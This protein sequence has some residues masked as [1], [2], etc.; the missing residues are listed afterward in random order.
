MFAGL[1]LFPVGLWNALL[2][3]IGSVG[4]SRQEKDQILGERIVRFC[5]TM[6][7][8]Y[9]KFGQIM[10]T[11]SD[12]FSADTIRELQRLQDDVPPSRKRDVDAVLKE[13]YGLER[14]NVFAWFGEEPIASAS[15]AQVHEARLK[16]GE[17]VAVKIVKRRVPAAL[18]ANLRFLAGAVKIMHALVPPIRHFNGPA[19]IRELAALLAPQIDM[20]REGR[21]M[22]HVARNFS[23]HPFVIIPDVHEA[24]C[25]ERV[26]VM[27]YVEG[28]PGR[29][30]DQVALP[31][32]QLARRLQD[33]VYTMLYM[34]GVAHGDPHPGN[35]RFTKDGKIIFLDFGITVHVSE[36]EKWGLASFLFASIRQEWDLATER[37]LV[38]FVIQ[39]GQARDRRTLFED[40]KAVIVHYFHEIADE[41][42]TAD[43]F[44]DITAVLKRHEAEYT[45]NFTKVELALASCEGFGTQIDPDIDVWANSRRFSDKYSPYMND[46]VREQF[47]EFFQSHTPRTMAM[48]DD[49]EQ[50][51]IASI[52][53]NRYFFPCTYPMFAKKAYGCRIEDMDGNVYIDLTGGY[54]PHILGYAHPEIVV[55]QTQLV[56][57]GCLN[58]MGN[59][60]EVELARM[61][62]DA[63]PG[64][65]YAC[66]SNSGTEAVIHALRICRAYRNRGK[67][68]KCEGHYHGFSDQAMVSSWFQQ[69]G[70]VE[71]PDAVAGCPGTPRETVNNTIVLQ[72]GHEESFRILRER[73]EEI[74]CVIME[75][76]PFSMGSMNV[77]FLNEMRSL[78]TELDIPL[79]FDEVVSGFRVAYGGAQ[80]TAGVTPDLTILGKI[81]GGGMP[82]GAVVGTRKLMQIAR[83]T[84][85]PFR[86]YE[87]RVFLG[88][89]MSGNSL[90]AGSGLAML[91]YLKAHPEVYTKLDE[92]TTWMKSALMAV[93]DRLDVPLRVKAIRSIFTVSFS[94][95]D[96]QFYREI[97]GGSDYKASIALAYYMR[98]HGVYMPEL[99]F[100]AL[101]YAHTREDLEIVLKAF[102]ISL[103]EM[104]DDGFFVS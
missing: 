50:F 18:R 5:Q 51:M 61:L 25:A 42:R 69:R 101:S 74:D 63:F 14:E 55:A 3:W 88:G 40:V 1:A 85:D 67:V 68:A 87:T 60:G 91:R 19:R 15:I 49:A 24:Y 41:W 30:F 29:D 8:L 13:A 22:R 65:D 98:K 82:C 80:T 92:H 64:M 48:R 84:A 58:A 52:H 2:Y 27:D 79:V 39:N 7:P 99:H 89:T 26:L 100:L 97:M 102:E 103:Q 56:A 75:P 16:T 12:A 21:N 28:I 46:G 31:R 76:L 47:N 90:S 77:E 70:P 54:G 36:A 94:H 81:I 78:C 35:V 44:A 53:M 104:K 83:S 95:R 10:S 23:N 66:L 59:S 4:K 93:A 45:P 86:D 72:Y 96:V 71:R 43:F 32:A 20:K 62:V 33:A 11:R 9:I 73:A 57:D 37:F 34:H 6:G 38:H 17:R